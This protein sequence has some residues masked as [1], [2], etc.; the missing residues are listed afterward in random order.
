MALVDIPPDQY[1]RLAGYAGL[2]V[3]MLAFWRGD[4]AISTVEAIEETPTSPADTIRRPGYFE[5]KGRVVCEDPL[6]APHSDREVV[7]Y[8]H[9]TYEEREERHVDRYGVP[10]TRVVPTLLAEDT[11]GCEFWV[12]DES[13]RVLVVPTGARI[14]GE[15]LVDR[16][17]V[18]VDDPEQSAEGPR[19]DDRVTRRHEV[20]G[21]PVGQDVYLLGPVLA[22]PGGGPLRFQADRREERP[23]ILSVRTEEEQTARVRRVASLWNLAGAAA[24]LTA[25]G[26]LLRAHGYL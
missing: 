16:V 9:R 24:G 10:R 4:A 3:S 23:F 19:Q 20:V 26:A 21:I 15:V 11:H 13:G 25:T 18:P 5:V 6:P 7:L 1:L 12:E 2:A 17:E 8:S 14:D 22:S